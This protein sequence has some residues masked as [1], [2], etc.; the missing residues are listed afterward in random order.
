MTEIG[1]ESLG[2][3]KLDFRYSDGQISFKSIID[4]T[5]NLNINFVYNCF[6]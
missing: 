6:I 4:E 5:V 1:K 3:V 2:V